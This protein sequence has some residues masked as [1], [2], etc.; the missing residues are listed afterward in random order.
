MPPHTSLVSGGFI[1]AWKNYYKR[2]QKY[3]YSHRKEIIGKREYRKR[4]Y[5]E[6]EKKY[7]HQYY[8]KRQ[9]ELR[10]RHR[11]HYYI[12]QGRKP[13]APLPI[14]KEE[15]LK[16]SKKRRAV[17]QLRYISKKKGAIGN[18]TLEEW[19][20]KKKEFNYCCAIC[21]KK[22]P[23]EDQ[24]FRKLEE[25]HIVPLSKGGT[26][27]IENIQPACHKCNCLKSDKSITAKK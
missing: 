17:R 22:E 15:R 14:D 13:F 7:Q 8:L 6:K 3:Y 27:Y 1:M 19:E 24:Y 10:K 26:N 9:V 2:Q 20:A 25:D 18:H 11:E 16:L 5:S 12:S 21:G 4:E 23:F